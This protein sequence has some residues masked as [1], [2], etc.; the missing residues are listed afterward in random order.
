MKNVRIERKIP[1]YGH[2]G[3]LDAAKERIVQMLHRK[4]GR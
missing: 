1:T 2:G 3:I 4:V